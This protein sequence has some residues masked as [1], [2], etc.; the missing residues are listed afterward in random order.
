MSTYCC[1]FPNSRRQTSEIMPSLVSAEDTARF[2]LIWNF[3]IH[4]AETVLLEIKL[5][6]FYLY[7]GVYFLRLTGVS[8]IQNEFSSV[9][10]KHWR[11][12][13]KLKT[14][15]SV[16]LPSFLLFLVQPHCCLAMPAAF[17]K[18]AKPTWQE[19]YV[20]PGR[21]ASQQTPSRSPPAGAARTPGR[22][23][24]SILSLC[25]RR[26]LPLT[27]SRSAGLH[28]GSGSQT[29]WAGGGGVPVTASCL[30]AQLRCPRTLQS[31]GRRT[32]AAAPGAA[33]LF[34]QEAQARHFLLPI[35]VALQLQVMVLT[36][37]EPGCQCARAVPPSCTR[38]T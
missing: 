13:I 27:A 37:S 1:A 30:G 16:S 25:R 33:R 7:K 31:V 32:P 21:R 8:G 35:W 19:S 2:D 15:V 36:L 26:A 4:S 28:R 6:S 5:V 3:A 18:L 34:I 14:V 10:F 9:R 23:S 22:R 20:P 17:K 11:Q 29:Y 38:S 12:K 24:W